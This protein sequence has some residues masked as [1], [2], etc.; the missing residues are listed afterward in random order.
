MELARFAAVEET[1]LRGRV[2]SPNACHDLTSAC[3]ITVPTFYRRERFVYKKQGTAAYSDD[4]LGYLI[5]YSV[6]KKG[7]RWHRHEIGLDS[8][9]APR[10]SLEGRMRARIWEERQKG[11]IGR[12]YEY[13]IAP[14]PSVSGANRWFPRQSTPISPCPCLLLQLLLILTILVMPACL[15]TSRVSSH[16]LSLRP[17]LLRSPEAGLNASAETREQRRNVDFPSN[18]LQPNRCINRHELG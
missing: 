6:R 1:G 7:S 8:V 5:Q 17:N 10:A 4:D 2:R 18:P 14:V 15:P 12:R 9:A 11:G 13:M 3:I 16:P